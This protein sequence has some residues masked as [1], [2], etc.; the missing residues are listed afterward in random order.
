MSIRTKKILRDLYS[1]KSKSFLVIA[2]I[3]FGVFGVGLLLNGF[4]VAKR[5]MN[6]SYADTNPASFSIRLI[7]VDDTLPAKAKT[8]PGVADAEMRRIILSRAETSEGKWVTAYLY[9]IDDFS[10]IRI[11]KLWWVDGEESPGRNEILLEREALSVAKVSLGDTI[12]MKLPQTRAANLMVTGSVHAPGLKPAWMEQVGYGFIS[13]ETLKEMNPPA[14]S[15]AT[16]M[17]LRVALSDKNADDGS[18]CETAFA[19]ADWCREEGCT[20]DRVG[21]FTP[22]EHPNGKQMNAILFLFQLFGGLSLALSAVL[23]INIISS[24]LSGHIRQIGVMKAIGARPSQVA[25]MYY[26]LVFL[27]GA[28]AT[29]IAVPIA[30]LASQTL[31][32]FCASMLN[33]SVESYQVPLWSVAIQM[34]TGL[35]VPA[36]AATYPIVK[37]GKITIVEALRD[38]GIREK[39]AKKAITSSSRRVFALAVRNTFRMRGRLA[40][41]LSTLA[42]GGAVF[43]VAMN[44]IASLNNTIANT[45]QSLNY[46]IQYALSM[47]YP[48]EQLQLALANIPQVKQIEY[49]S[50]SMTTLVREDGTEGNAFQL[51]APVENM[52]ALR[53]PVLKGRW[54]APGDTN[55][56]VINH[57]FAAEYPELQIGDEIALRSNGKTTQWKLAGIVK[58]VGADARAYVSQSEYIRLFEQEGKSRALFV[59]NESHD[60]ETEL[61]VSRQIEKRL[62]NGGMD[63]MRSSTIIETRQIFDNHLLLIA[64]FLMMAAVLVIIVGIMGLVSSTGINLLERMREIGVMRSVGATPKIITGIIIGEGLLTG[65]MSWAI[66]CLLSAPMTHLTGNLFGNIFL[67]TPLDSVISPTGIII[68][69]AAVLITTIFVGWFAAQNALGKPVNETLKYE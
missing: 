64:G 52:E 29:A 66:A 30:M 24:M 45:E 69:L 48:D 26:H 33:F 10:D 40:L 13:E 42:A 67:Q 17:E 38:Y 14:G 9:V 3:L 31:V 1:Q 49:A 2:A 55:A 19:M 23:V 59:T 50:G 8:Y 5:E 57:A 22:G 39:K 56:V 32:N 53:L 20:V 7:P 68:W 36:L 37:S 16:F 61:L 28:V 6:R 44:M 41:S 62:Q 21:V 46:D 11:D 63:I 34:A 60:N 51:V 12:H 27:L 47:A 25:R 54:L 43:L 15:P 4:A 35:L 58:E 65:L 18:I